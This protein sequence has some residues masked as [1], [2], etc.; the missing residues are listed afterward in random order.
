M[1]PDVRLLLAATLAPIVGGS[2]SGPI[3]DLG[4]SSYQ[5]YHEAATGLNIWKGCVLTPLSDSNAADTKIDVRSIRYAS[6]PVG[7]LRWQ[8][9]RP[10][11]KN[12]GRIIP[13]VDQPPVC[14]QSGAAGTPAIYGFNSGPGDEDCLFL[15]VYAPSGASDLPVFVWIRKLLILSTRPLPACSSADPA[16]RQTVAAMDCLALCM[17]PLRS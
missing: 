12:N 14:P 4:Y 6:P 13:A 15:N 10:P 8:P 16:D 11:A 5:G 2:S 1:K 17:I 9:P 3:V 7:Q